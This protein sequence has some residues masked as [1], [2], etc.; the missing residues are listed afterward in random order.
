MNRRTYREYECVLYRVR[1]DT[2]EWRTVVVI[3][4][5]VSLCFFMIPI[6]VQPDKNTEDAKLFENYIAQY[7]KFYKN[8]SAEYKERFERFLV[9]DKFSRNSS[10]KIDRNI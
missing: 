7:N 4:L 6:K 10:L 9:N 8:D 5:V 3:V 2:M 1:R